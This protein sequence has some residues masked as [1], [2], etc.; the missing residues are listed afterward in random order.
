MITIGIL[1]A[2]FPRVEAHKLQ[3]FAIW[4]G[5]YCEEYQ[6]NDNK[7]QA[8]FFAQIGHES[9]DLRWMAEIWGPTAQ[10][11]RYER[12]TTLA[13]S[14]GNTE[15]GDGSR[16]RGRG[17]IQITGRANYTEA[18][19]ALSVDFVGQ[20]ALLQR[21][22]YAVQS[23]CWWWK[24]RGLNEIADI[25]TED[26]FKAMTKKINGGLNGYPDRL[27]RWMRLREVFKLD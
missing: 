1:R 5:R 15:A 9:G 21:P 8:A 13:A 12:P 3:L 27:A 25:D 20:P 24:N 19:I 18:S 23:A 11:M 16:F 22:Q 4:F 10:Q 26:S 6:I 7:R 2:V 17:L 14:L